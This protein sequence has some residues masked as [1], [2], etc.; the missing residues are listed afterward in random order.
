MV[1]PLFYC[2]EKAGGAQ[3][4]PAKIA[5]VVSGRLAQRVFFSGKISLVEVVADDERLEG[6][7]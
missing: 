5:T 4:W 7:S 2:N 3:A 6:M 1:H